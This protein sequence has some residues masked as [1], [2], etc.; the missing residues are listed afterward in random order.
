MQPQ[1]FEAATAYSS[2]D[3]DVDKARGL[4][5]PTSYQD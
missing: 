2:S 5:E 3:E 4:D 1:A